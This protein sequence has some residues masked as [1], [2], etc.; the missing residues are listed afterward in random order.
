MPAVS[1]F[2]AGRQPTT[3]C[4]I[5]QIHILYECHS[6]KESMKTENPRRNTS[7]ITERQQAPRDKRNKLDKGRFPRATT[8]QESC[9]H[10]ETLP[11]GRAGASERAQFHGLTQPYG[12][13][14]GTRELVPGQGAN[15]DAGGR[16]AARE[17]ARRYGHYV[18]RRGSPAG[19]RYMIFLTVACISDA[20]D[21]INETSNRP[22]KLINQ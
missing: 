17:G 4:L 11:A 19:S 10:G 8:G 21:S 15:Q 9:G 6:K 2:L 22:G 3:P 7:V 16:A 20:Y 14:V 12:A 13:A 5:K 1:R 18:G